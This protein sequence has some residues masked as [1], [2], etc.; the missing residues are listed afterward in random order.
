MNIL[1]NLVSST[2]YSKEPLI[3]P[4]EC[5]D[6]EEIKPSSQ[7][8]TPL[9]AYLKTY[10]ENGYQIM[11]FFTDYG[12][13]RVSIDGD[14]TSNKPIIIT[15]HDIG[16]NHSACYL[17]FFN[18]MKSYDPKWRYFT[19][20]HIDAPQ[21]HYEDNVSSHGPPQFYEDESVVA[22]DLLELCT[23]IEEIRSA[24]HIDRFI[25]FGVGSAC[26]IWSYYAMNYSHRLRGMILL[27]GVSNACSWK[28]WIFDSM[29]STLGTTSQFV[30]DSFR[31]S[32]LTRYFPRVMPQEIYDY[33][34]SEFERMDTSSAMK[35]FRGFARRQELSK[36]Q[37]SKI[38]SKTLVIC[39]EYSR[40]KEETI[41]FQ[42][43]MP[44]EYT[45]FVL[46]DKAGF[47]LTESHPQ[48]LCSSMD[49]FMQSLG[50]TTLSLKNKY[51]V[52]EEEYAD[53]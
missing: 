51:G 21:H 53:L 39:G 13:Q 9:K 14:L 22:F 30:I 3:Q 35:Y 5:K 50:L 45:S 36:E 7:Q 8:P 37:L 49:L 12:T 38:K 20:I 42:A 31:R 16:I 6:K 43:K 4:A 10:D 40:V 52:L 44:R 27:N 29:L 18:M 28:E 11:D 47:L 23:Q 25:A 48:L 41:K 17:S 32:L 19:I 15:Y 24:L 26:N 46:L 1:S 2:E 33:F 34:Y